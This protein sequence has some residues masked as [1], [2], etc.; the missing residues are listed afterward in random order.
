MQLA[1]ARQGGTRW[2][3]PAKWYRVDVGGGPAG[4]T[5]LALD[6]N[7]PGRTQEGKEQ[8]QWLEA[9]LAGPRDTFTLVIGH[10]PVFSN[11]THGDTAHLVADWAPL[12]ERHR[13]HA[14]LA[15]HDHDLQHLELA[16]RFTSFVISGGG[17]HGPRPLRRRDRPAPFG[18]DVRGFTHLHVGPETLAFAHHGVDGTRFHRFTKRSDG[19]VHVE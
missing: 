10:H 11:G 17:G 15:G 8:L 18:R 6:S 14:Y 19:R 13:V 3:M 7:L 5:I 4:L 12:F 2:R 1:Y 9:Q 16:D